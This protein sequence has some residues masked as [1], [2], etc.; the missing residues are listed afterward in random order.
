MPPIENPNVE[1]T[2]Q[3]DLAA[4]DAALDAL[5]LENQDTPEPTPTPTP[6]PKPTGDPAPEPTPTPTEEPDPT[7]KPEGDPDPAL[8]PTPKPGEEE[9]PEFK[10]YT[11][12]RNDSPEKRA[13]W[14]DLRTK[15]ETYKKEVHTLKPKYEEAVKALASYEKGEKLPEPIQKELEEL[16]T[17]RRTMDV[18][19]DPEFTKKF[20]TAIGAAEEEIYGIM[21][22]AGASDED[23]KAMKESG[24]VRSKD[25]KWW[26]KNVVSAL[27]G[28]PEY[29]IQKNKLVSKLDEVFKLEGDK[30]K[31][32]E[33]ATKN[34]DTIKK[35]K[36]E[37]AVKEREQFQSVV[38]EEIDKVRPLTAWANKLEIPKDANDDVRKQ[39][40]SHN[41]FV[42]ETEMRFMQA[43]ESTDPRV[44]AQTAIFAAAFPKVQ[45]DLQLMTQYAQKLEAEL[46]AIKSAGSTTSMGRG[47]TRPPAPT[48]KMDMS[49]DDAIEAGLREAGA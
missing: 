16:R 49:D 6:T 10:E 31:E 13:Q 34:Y 12:P 7:P 32:I 48:N 36:E 30:A 1:V 14:K 45:G 23:L 43:L 42:E 4:L 26:S 40:E 21:K 33:S 17:F 46:K 25:M 22:E 35:Q 15:A 41:A 2:D 27:E 29:A 19:S 3:S 47:L 9:D 18:K 11:E 39:I 28:D 24:G 37:V 5:P 38:L 20:E 8:T 44:R